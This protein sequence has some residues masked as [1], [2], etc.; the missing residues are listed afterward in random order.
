[1]S[2]PILATKLYIPP[3]R[4]HLVNRTRLLD[5]LNAGL[6]GKLTLIAAPAGFGKTT[7]VSSWI[8]DLRLTIDDSRGDT[9]TKEAIVNRQSKIVNLVAWLSLDEG[10]N[11]PKRFLAYLI[12]ALQQG[13][14]GFGESLLGALHS[15]QPSRDP[16]ARATLLT[17]L[18]NELTT[19][20]GTPT[21]S[22]EQRI[23]LV[24]D[25]Y[26]VITS[27]EID[28]ALTFLLDYLPPHVHLVITTR[29]DPNLP[30]ARLRAR[31][32]L[33]DVRAGD[34]RFTEAEAADFLNGVM[35]LTLSTAEVAAL[36]SR[37]E[38]WI[39]G[40]QLA[41]LSMR[42]HKDVAG[43][44]K[45]FAGDNHYI[46]DYLVEEVLQHQP[47]EVRTFLLQ[48]AIL[49]RLSGPLCAAVV[50]NLVTGEGSLEARDQHLHDDSQAADSPQS[51]VFHLPSPVS[52]LK[53]QTILESLEQANLFLVPLD[54][55][56]Q[57]YRYHHLFADVLYAHLVEEQPD[58]LP[59]L[60]RRASA[61]YAQNDRP[62][63]AI[64][65]ALAA[66]DFAQAA[67]LIESVWRVMDINL[68][69]ATWLTWVKALPD[70]L[71][72]SRPVLSLGYAWALL[73]GGELE[74]SAARLHDA[75][76]WLDTSAEMGDA[77][78]IVTDEKA[79][80][81]L[82]AS[83]A[84]AY[85]FLAQAQGDT[86]GSITY[87]RRALDLLPQE[88][89]SGRAVPAAILGLAYWANGELEAAHQALT[90]AMT[91]FQ[92]TGN[93]VAA[94]SPTY[95][96]ADIRITQGRLRDAV[97]IYEQSLQ[98]T[99]VHTDGADVLP[100][101]L[102]APVPR[103]TAD[104]YLG[105][106]EL[107]HEQGD[108][109]AATRHLQQSEALGEQA[110]LPDW[111]HRLRIVQA[112]M[113]A[114]QGDLDEALNLL[115]AAERLY[116][117]TPVP[118]V[119]PIA[120]WK[121]RVWVKQG[122]LGEALAWVQEREQS[123]DDDLSYLREFEHITLA[124]VLL[125]QQ[126]SKREPGALQAALDLLTRLLTAAEAGGRMGS[127]LEILVLQALAHAAQ[128]NIA[129]A[130]VPLARALTL[131]EPEG[132]V[133]LFVDEGPPMAV[134]LQAAAQ[135]GI[136]PHYVQQLRTALAPTAG[137]TPVT[138][139]VRV[140]QAAA[141]AAPPSLLEPLSD[142]ELEVL[143]LLN[144]DLKGPEIARELVVSLNTMR[145]HTKN[146]YSKLGV[147]SRRAAVRRAKELELI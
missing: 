86:A 34:L 130:L 53:A 47:E 114:S 87:A 80:Q 42:G 135:Q 24:L 38:G 83:V 9:A 69:S 35:G 132:Y 125:A 19:H 51:S 90:E 71:V 103:G 117:R 44:I 3:P 1:M 25:D 99:R 75:E 110:A 56:R 116:Y 58:Q 111:P 55:K 43:F 81:S 95:G 91:H 124:R 48:T 31:G 66:Q 102:G 79:F 144:T 32:Q 22:V 60:H 17:A 29:E 129:Q 6:Y 72:R 141:A 131:A 128:D 126:Q 76:R 23:L 2:T 41:A 118:N 36:E 7:L 127:A 26:H 147:N 63:D 121:A 136:A 16:A 40:L 108:Q 96:L 70:E 67:D 8:A 4:P 65:H 119:R 13:L 33:T 15:S 46:V 123:V 74:A 27:Q 104:L 139:P 113:K 105:L 45:A 30:L 54:D 37:T 92:M 39:A 120:A 85:A 140:V 101:G 112:R 115:N 82:A 98:F 28:Q 97:R 145:T 77:T 11:D 138:P 50:G 10:D 142:R 73:N 106:S 88:D 68:E 52:R 62:A 21:P 49:D 18:L 64:R 12:T 134:L 20:T 109:E 122:R 137:D 57:W 100:T 143:R 146:I 61:W 84:A 133:R 89:H 107:S 94:I 78:M 59:T 14:A 93:T 5:R